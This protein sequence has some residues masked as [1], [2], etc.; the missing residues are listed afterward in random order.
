[1]SDKCR[2]ALYALTSK[3][4]ELLT[5]VEAA[6]EDVGHRP[7]KDIIAE[8]GPIYTD[9]LVALATPCE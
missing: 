1:M 9:S 6:G 7:I 5:A 3:V 2:D 8:L 4:D